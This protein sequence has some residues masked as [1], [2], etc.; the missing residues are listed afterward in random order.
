M[1]TLDG[2]T[3]GFIT[4]EE[5]TKA[6]NLFSQPLPVSDSNE[7]IALDLFGTSRTLQI[8]GTKTGTTAAI[9][10]FITKFNGLQNGQQVKIV[11]VSDIHPSNINVLINTFRYRFS[12]GSPTKITFSF[13]LLETS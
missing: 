11:Y 6:S 13:S 12:A 1:A 2:T 7:L 10:T 9:Q 3:L 4:T 8:E 5:N